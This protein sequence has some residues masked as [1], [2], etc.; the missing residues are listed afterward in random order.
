MAIQLTEIHDG[1]VLK[2]TITGQL[3][4]DDFTHLVPATEEL[5]KSRGKLH[6]LLEL[7]D[8]HGWD[9]GAMWEDLKFDLKHFNDIERLAIVGDS[10]WEERMSRF[11]KPFTSAEVRYFQES[12]RESAEK[13]VAETPAKSEPGHSSVV[14]TYDSHTAAEAAVKELKTA[15]FDFKKL[16]IVG[17]DY[18]TDEHV[19][20]YYNTGDRMRAWGRV[21]AFWGA[22]WGFM[23]GSA[24]FFIPG[25]GPLVIAGPLVSWIVGALEGAVV[26]GGLSALG[27]GLASVGIPKDSILKYETAMKS[28]KFLLIVHGTADDVVTAKGI[29]AGT[30][31]ESMDFHDSWNP[32]SN[33][34]SCVC[35][36]AV[37]RD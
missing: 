13:W 17:R 31:S 26:V 32:P 4:K 10:W 21:G 18:H 33:P 36:V 15:N 9:A 12:E 8:F 29:L 23:F 1:Q 14:A 24:F 20:G 25:I 27:G 37:C 35:D 2:V 6:I 16:S 28:D 19:V 34:T 3:H 7:V 11:C 30:D 22:L 5:I